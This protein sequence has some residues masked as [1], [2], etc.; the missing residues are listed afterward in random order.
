[1]TDIDEMF[2]ELDGRQRY[3]DALTVW[4]AYKVHSEGTWARDLQAN[5]PDKYRAWQRPIKQRYRDKHREKTR[6]WARA[7][8][9]AYR[10]RKKAAKLAAKEA[11]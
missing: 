8:S 6:E 1:V 3:H 11:P 4:G 10:D 2:A 5:H 9:K 7:N